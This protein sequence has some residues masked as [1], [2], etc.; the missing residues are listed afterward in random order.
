MKQKITIATRGSRLALRQS[1]I[2]KDLL[3]Q[4][5]PELIVGFLEVTTT[6]DIDQTTP[7]SAFGNTGVFVKGLEQKLLSGEA[8]LAVHSLK[9]VPA[10]S[11]PELMLAAFP[12]RED[13]RDVLVTLNG[14]SL[15]DLKPGSIIGTSSPGRQEQLKIL[16]PDLVFKSIRGNVDTRVNKVLNGEYDATILAAAGLN[17]LGYT[18]PSEN[19]FSLDEIVP[20]P[21]QGA[22]VIQANKTNTGVVE[23]IKQINDETIEKQVLAERRFMQIIGGGCKYPVGANAEIFPDK[24]IFRAVAFKPEFGKLKKIKVE[25]SLENLFEVAENTARKMLLVK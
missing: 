3:L 6:G 4:R 16:R 20:S 9:D 21:G 25:T 15:E 10:D 7:L 12:Q 14:I 18:I 8:D 23:M 13:P 17:R 1:E 22:L 5:F 2:V 19:Y 24:V 11:N